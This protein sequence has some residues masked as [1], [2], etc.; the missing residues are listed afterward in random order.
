VNSRRIATLAI[1]PLAVLFLGDAAC[2]KRDGAEGE[3]AATP[4]VAV[5]PVPSAV[6]AHRNAEAARRTELIPKV[7][8]SDRDTVVRRSA[9]RALARIADP[10]AIERLEKSLGDEDPEVV[11]W[12]ALGLGATCAGREPAV[13]RALV[14]RAASFE[15]APAPL[16]APRGDDGTRLRI[17]ENSSLAD[18]L[19]RCGS[20]LAEQTL[21]AWLTGPRPRAEAAALAL[22]RLAGR[23]HRL[24]DATIV[25]L[26]EAA[27]QKP[28]LEGA[29]YPL[30]RLDVVSE[31]IAKRLFVVA[32]GALSLP[33]PGRIF[34]IRS[35]GAAG[36]VA[37]DALRAVFVD[38][39]ATIE[40]R[41]AAATTLGRLGSEA[42]PALAGGL[43]EIL[44]AD[45]AV[46]EAWLTASTG[47]LLAALRALPPKAGA[48]EALIRLAELPLPDGV[49][50]AL[51]RR[52]VELRCMA[53]SVL[54]HTASLSARLVQCAPEGFSR[55]S[56]LATIRVLDR[57]ALTAAR[58]ESWKKYAASED[59]AVRRAALGLVLAHPEIPPIAPLIAKA[60]GSAEPG[61]VVQAARVLSKDPRR[62]GTRAL[63]AAPGEPEAP[64]E[65]IVEALGRAFD[66]PRPP[67]EIETRVALSAAAGALGILRLKP[68]VEKLCASDNATT[69]RAAE[70][71]LRALG[72]G[73]ATCSQ[74]QG[75]EPL[76][77]S[78][79]R[80][81]STLTFVTDSGRYGMRLDPALAPLAVE[82]VVGLARE[83]FFDHM[84]IHRVVPGS[85]VQLGDKVGDGYG[86]SGKPPLPTETA[87]LEFQ[88]Y[89]VGMALAGRDTG[90][91]QI[92]VT[93]TQEPA[94][95]G[96]YPVLGWA[97][98]DWS[99]VA[100]GDVVER[101]EIKD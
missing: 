24:D 100:E 101:V 35:L 18:A 75:K 38:E 26:L 47:P 62:A 14:A 60:L 53:A 65:E 31:A 6:A 3:S 19:S 13:V 25:A 98:S 20:L 27:A 46:D 95:Y 92:F 52:I 2:R 43:A 32:K 93:L 51:A 45:R 10:P 36:P 49:S 81:P 79:A 84:V 48:D 40:A 91:S 70:S 76:N 72:D 73:G 30:S 57:G 71:A 22:G 16:P 11:A 39:R 21:A 94:L 97:D 34:A 58:F 28:P 42:A 17:D 9:A 86:G 50:P 12:S 5:S 55:V 68:R 63:E 69:R 44:K 85:V 88:R 74:P 96:D 56:A 1:L 37:A 87:P 29:L 78:G 82:R 15:A 99:M 61:V 54:A 67:D 77:V 33:D 59:P 83:G 41:A 66:A 64:S 90:S 8:L 7:A 89:F 4:A 23:R 80:A